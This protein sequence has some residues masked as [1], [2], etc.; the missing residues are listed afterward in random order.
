MTPFHRGASSQ[1]SVHVTGSSPQTGHWGSKGQLSSHSS[2]EMPTSQSVFQS[3]LLG[4]ELLSVKF[5]N[6]LVGNCE[7]SDHSTGYEAW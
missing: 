1:P 7:V 5:T 4:C 3:T 2:Q 6:W